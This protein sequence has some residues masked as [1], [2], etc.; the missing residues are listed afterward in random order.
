[1][2]SFPLL[3]TGAVGQYPSSREVSFST[4]VMRFVDGGEQRFRELRAPVLRWTIHLHNVDAA[5]LEAID[6]FFISQQGEFGSFS[7]SQTRGT[8][9]SIQTAAL[10]AMCSIG[11]IWDEGS[12]PFGS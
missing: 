12:G 8:D 1:M 5:E 10:R 3:K 7:N 2:A 6:N 4:E 11:G 9:K